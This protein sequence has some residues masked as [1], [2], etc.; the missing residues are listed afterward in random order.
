MQPEELY[1]DEE[2]EGETGEAGNKEVLLL[3]QETHEAQG[4]QIEI[5]Q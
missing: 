5:G 1:D 4:D 2:Q 3:V